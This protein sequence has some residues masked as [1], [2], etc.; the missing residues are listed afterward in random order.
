MSM[1]STVTEIEWSVPRQGGGVVTATKAVGQTVINMDRSQEP[2]L[3]N[4][5][6]L[7]SAFLDEFES[8]SDLADLMPDARAEV[9]AGIAAV[10]GGHSLKSLR[11]SKGMSQSAFA[12]ALGTSQSR[13]SLYEARQQKPSEDALR[14]MSV[15]LD[16][17]FNTLMEA[18]ARGE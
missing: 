8:H 18:L 2:R 3:P 15:A 14:R 9:G 7:L 12:I 11:L 17:D 4:G 1:V 6:K 13:V 5:A 16:V 10:R